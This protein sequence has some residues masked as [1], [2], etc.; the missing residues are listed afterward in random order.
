MLYIIINI[1]FNQY[2]PRRMDFQSSSNSGQE[3]I[4]FILRQLYYYHIEI[5]QLVVVHCGIPRNFFFI[6]GGGFKKFSGGQR[7][8][9]MEI[10]GR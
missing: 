7:A 6:G 10:W 5:M 9:R 2:N 4:F 1:I 8:K 3:A